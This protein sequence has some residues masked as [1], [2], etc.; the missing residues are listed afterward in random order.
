MAPVGVSFTNA[1]DQLPHSPYQVSVVH[2]FDLLLDLL[3]LLR[4]Q[5]EGAKKGT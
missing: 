5:T 3:V 1:N 4:K 2:I